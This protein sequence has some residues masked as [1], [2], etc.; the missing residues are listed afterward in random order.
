M[1][2]PKNYNSQLLATFFVQSFLWLCFFFF[3]RMALSKHAYIIVHPK[4]RTGVGIKHIRYIYIYIINYRFLGGL[5]SLPLWLWLC[6][7]ITPMNCFYPSQWSTVV[8]PHYGWLLGKVVWNMFFHNLGISSSQLTKSII[9]QR[10][11]SPT[12]QVFFAIHFD[13]IAIGVAPLVETSKSSCS[14]L[15]PTNLDL[16]RGWHTTAV[17]PG[18]PQRLHAGHP[19][20]PSVPW[21]VPWGLPP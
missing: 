2:F 13:R 11:G 3:Y 20:D 14:L 12:N 18:G 15:N 4:M 5:V 10:G 19:A 8:Y 17:L 6:W 1:M 21:G 9:F 7:L 16:I